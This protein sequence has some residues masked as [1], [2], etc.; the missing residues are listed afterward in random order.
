MAWIN[1]FWIHEIICNKSD[2]V[3][4]LKFFIHDLN[5]ILFDFEIFFD[6]LLRMDME[7]FIVYHNDST[8]LVT[9]L[10]K[11]W[12][13]CE[14]WLLNFIAISEKWFFKRLIVWENSWFSHWI[15]KSIFKIWLKVIIW[16]IKALIIL[17]GSPLIL[18]I[19]NF[20]IS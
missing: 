4:I 3:S 16:N 10:L 9:Y 15:W 12:G 13:I 2:F 7:I 20:W 11:C 5:Y 14:N 17:L 19:K 1:V 8:K 18:M 6:W